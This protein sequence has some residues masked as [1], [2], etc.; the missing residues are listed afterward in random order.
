MNHVSVF[1]N[2]TIIENGIPFSLSD[3]PVALGDWLLTPVRCLFDGNK[4]TIAHKNG[5]LTVNHEKDYDGFLKPK[6]N[7]FRIIAS[8]VFILPG[9]IIGSAF[10]GLSYLFSSI[11]ERHKLAI[12]HYTPV[13]RTVG[14]ENDRLSLEAIK[15]ELLELYLDSITLNQPTKNLIIYAEEGVQ[16]KEDPGILG[17]KPKKLIMV[18]AQLIHGPAAG[19]DGC[20]DENLLRAGWEKTKA[21]KIDDAEALEGSFVTQWK[22]KSL[23]AALKDI[24][25]RLSFFSFERYHRIYVI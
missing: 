5:I 9:L 16:I 23:A 15:D 4:V 21:N 17:F 10:K 13:D 12:L 3:A 11:R 24:P 2:N 22:V 19:L 25:P 6:R 7:L 8:I 20:L 18:G 1:F 14:S